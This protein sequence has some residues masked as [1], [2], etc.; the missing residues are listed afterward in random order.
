M[1]KTFKLT[2]SSPEGHIFEDDVYSIS[3]RGSN[4]DLA[5]LPNHIPFATT[6]KPSTVKII[7]NDNTVKLA[8]IKSG[9]LT[10]S[11]ENTILLST[12]FKWQE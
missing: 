5:I 2:I 4:G 12:N 10:V 9:V 8:K 11:K 3:L 6:V 7:L 1:T